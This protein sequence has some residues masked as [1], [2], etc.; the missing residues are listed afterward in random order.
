MVVKPVN[1]VNKKQKKMLKNIE[2]GLFLFP[3]STVVYGT[4]SQRVTRTDSWDG[5]PW[6][7][8]GSFC[9]LTPH[10]FLSLVRLWAGIQRWIICRRG[11]KLNDFN[12]FFQWKTLRISSRTF[13]PHFSVSTKWL[14]RARVAGRMMCLCHSGSTT[15]SW[16]S[17]RAAGIR[18]FVSMTYPCHRLL[19]HRKSHTLSLP[20]KEWSPPSSPACPPPLH[21]LVSHPT[22]W[23]NVSGL[24]RGSVSW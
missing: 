10:R 12:F 1:T 14:R 8:W 17:C 24:K 23:L 4:T 11:T 21:P 19:F 15:S 3:Q 18:M 5:K 20:P 9:Q 22:W 7:T 16:C 6:N 2:F 13:V